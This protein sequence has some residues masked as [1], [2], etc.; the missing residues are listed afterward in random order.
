VNNGHD[1]GD[2]AAHALGLLE[3]PEAARVQA[4]IA[5]C[6][7]CHREWVD[8][9]RTSDLLDGVPPE[10]FLDG[11]PHPDADAVLQRAL[12]RVRGESRRGRGRRRLVLGVAA[13]V[14][15]VA[16]AGGA[17]A[18]GRATAPETSV[19]AAPSAPAPG[20]RVLEGSDGGV[21]LV[22]TITPAR[23]WVR[24]SA[25]VSGIPAG[26]RCELVV[27]AKDGTEEEAGSWLTGADPAGA[28]VDGSALISPEDVAGVLVRNED[29]REFVSAT[30]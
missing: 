3:G 20:A 15:G 22:A 12:W 2:V 11:P 5:V 25:D 8:L 1:P 30:A 6:P 7:Q 9:R 23:G 28:T 21:R 4:H 29:G 14:T 27:V 18:I 17:V 24:V 10:M 16:L 26:E 19:T 13:A